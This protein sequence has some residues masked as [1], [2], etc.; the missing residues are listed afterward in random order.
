MHA[1]IDWSLSF[2]PISAVTA[3]QYVVPLCNP[4]ATVNVVGNTLAS[5]TLTFGWP[6]TPWYALYVSIPLIGVP[7]ANVVGGFH[8][9]TA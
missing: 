5:V 3:Q 1:S 4:E 8:E 7:S 2:V 6:L 9:S